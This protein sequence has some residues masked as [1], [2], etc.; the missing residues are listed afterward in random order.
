MRE[1]L[2]RGVA[3][4][5]QGKF[6]EAHEAWE[7]AWLEQE[8][9]R[10]LFLQGLIQ[11]SAGFFKATVQNQPSGCV[12]LLGAGL[13][14][15][16][17]LPDSYQGVELLRFRAAVLRS[18]AQARCWLAGEASGVVRE[19]IPLLELLDTERNPGVS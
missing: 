8:D 7:E 18:L 9:E 10:K 13:E 12:K 19:E 4:F 2:E 1:A 17:P 14:K 11:V 3:L 5:N 16:A 15:L 6:W